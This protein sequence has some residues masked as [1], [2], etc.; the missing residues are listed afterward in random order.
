MKAKLIITAMVIL[1]STTLTMANPS[2]RTLTFRTTL[3]SVLIQPVNEEATQ[4]SLPLEIQ[5][6]FFRL[7]K[8]KT[9]KMIDL[10]DMIKPEKEEPLPF[11]LNQ[12]LRTI[13]R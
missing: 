8:E 6:E 5:A 7:R 4:D 13:R 9:V 1:F 2:K 10:T 3:G 12:V 11:D